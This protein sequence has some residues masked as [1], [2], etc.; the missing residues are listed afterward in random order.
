MRRRTK[1]LS[2]RPMAVIAAT[3]GILIGALDAGEA[4][5]LIRSLFALFG[6]AVHDPV[7][8]PTDMRFAY[9]SASP[10]VPAGILPRM[11]I[12]PRLT[13]HTKLCVRLCDGRFF[14][15]SVPASC[16]G[17][18]AAR[19]CA[20]LCPAAATMVFRG[21]VIEDAIAENG[22]RYVN[23]TNAFVFRQQ[24]VPGCTCNGKDGFGLAQIDVATDPT[25]RAGDVVATSDGL[26]VVKRP[27]RA[28]RRTAGFSPIANASGLPI[29][30]RRELAT[31]RVSSEGR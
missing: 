23:L 11:P 1:I 31:A 22:E 3:F 30:L 25:L 14:P 16:S 10:Q 15:L 2:G 12:K 17:S 8:A 20:A 21:D 19:M 4:A 18:T 26:K 9:A 24:T 29:E 28:D 7:A 5:D 6:A 27:S 13:G